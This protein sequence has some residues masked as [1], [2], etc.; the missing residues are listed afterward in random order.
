MLSDSVKRIVLICIV[1]HDLFLLQTLLVF[2]WVTM[3]A[4]KHGYA[5]V[6]VGTIRLLCF[7]YYFQCHFVLSCISLMYW[8]LKSTLKAVLTCP[9]HIFF[10]LYCLGFWHE[11][12][13][14]ISHYGYICCIN[15]TILTRLC[16]WSHILTDAV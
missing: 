7:S 12:N 15:R 2:F 13:R 16:Q 8:D 10:F 11:I 1:L 5:I 6:R 9:S 4:S 3:V 14:I